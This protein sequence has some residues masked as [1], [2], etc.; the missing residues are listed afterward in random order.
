MAYDFLRWF[1]D[2]LAFE[3]QYS[4]KTIQ[5]YTR[6]VE[7]FFN[8]L[9]QQCGIKGK[10]AMEEVTSHHIRGFLQDLFEKKLTK[11]TIARKLAAIRT[12]CR[13]AFKSGVRS[14][15]PARAVSTPKRDKK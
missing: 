15:N 8:Y 7:D 2:Y 4:P 6:D 12:L 3:K 13:F 10:G 14:D 9:E 1:Y 11:A 5:S